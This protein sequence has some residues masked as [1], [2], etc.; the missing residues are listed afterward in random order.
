MNRFHILVWT[1][2]ITLLATAAGTALAD[3]VPEPVDTAAPA[4]KKKDVPPVMHS[5][6]G[7]RSKNGSDSL[8]LEIIGIRQQYSGMD[9]STYDNT[10]FSPKSALF[11]RDSSKLYVNS[12][13]GCH[14]TVFSVPSLR[15]QS[16]ISYSFP[17]G[18]GPKWCRP[19]DYYTFTHYDDGDRRKFVGKPVEGTLSHNGRY[20]WVT[21]YRRS[22][23]INAQ[24]PSAVAVIDTRTDSIIRMFETGPLPKMIAASPDNRRIA[25]THWGDNTV[26]LIDIS[27]PG[28]KDWHH[29]RPIVIGRKLKLDHPLDKS[30]NRDA[31]SGNLLRGT[32][33]TPDGKWL[34]VSGMHGPLQVIDVENGQ[35]VGHANEIYGLRHLA[36]SDG[37]VY[38]SHNV[39]GM[40][41][42]FPLD[43]LISDA[44]KARSEGRKSLR[45][46]KVESCKVGKGAR[47]LVISPDGRYLFVACNTES[48]LYV[49]DTR[50]MKVVDSL[51]IDSYPVG[52][53]ISPD[54]SL[55]AVTSQGREGHGGN[56]LNLVKVIRHYYEAPVTA[57]T[58]S[59][60]DDPDDSH[61]PQEPSIT[62]DY[63]RQCRLAY[64]LHNKPLLISTGILLLAVLSILLY[65]LFRNSKSQ[66]SEQ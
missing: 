32:V 4:Q 41:Y 55:L 18:V 64:L 19:S 50:S 49:V 17:S 39:G 65:F 2:C 48:A 25:V 53:A 15:R 54:G 11:S 66:D 3:N 12:L 35:L 43:A 27:A 33:F 31:N 28:I 6:V 57:P 13:E 58:D 22:F 63:H 52:L 23:D 60:A 7:D 29:L 8:R 20:L 51:T 10:I 5:A 34:L 9:R 61:A 45:V 24:D 26:G 14:T 1:I 16:L 40:V 30:V 44:V 46:G 36:I 56:A 59:I 37:Y 42:R 21:F 38:G 62:I 47:T